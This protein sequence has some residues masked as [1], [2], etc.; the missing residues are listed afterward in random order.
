MTK[1]ARKKFSPEQKR[2]AVQEYVSGQKSAP[3]IAAELGCDTQN[4]Y[5]WKTLEEEANKGVRIDELMNE[6]NTQAMAE[7]LFEK[8][9]EIEMYQKK[10]AELTIINDLLKK[11]PTAQVLAR[12]SEL[13]GLIK[14]SSKSA[15]KRKRVKR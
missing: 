9:L 4:I 10:I 2:K 1:K 15:Q 3:Q 12:E 11:F 8:E 6:G 13:T 5:R 7:K 14:T